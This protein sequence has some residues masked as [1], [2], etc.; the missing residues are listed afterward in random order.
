MSSF[1][2]KVS[3][4]MAIDPQTNQTFVR[5][6]LQSI[7]IDQSVRPNQLVLV[8][9]GPCCNS[10]KTLI[11]RFR[12]EVELRVIHNKTKLG[13]AHCLNIGLDHCEHELV[14]RMDAD[15]VCYR[16]RLERQVRRFVED[17]RLDILSCWAKIIDEHGGTIGLR[18]L[19]VEHSDII[20]RLWRCPLIHPAVMYRKSKIQSIGGYKN[21][22]LRR[23]DYDLWFR[24]AE[25]GMRFGN[26]SE[27]LL[28]YRQVSGHRSKDK[29]R[30]KFQQAAIG[31]RGQFRLEGLTWKI[32]LPLSVIGLSMLPAW[33]Y[34]F[35]R[36]YA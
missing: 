3:V 31:V 9:D 35:V 32:L 14:A 17:T 18:R 5:E 21:E 12:E 7:V 6:A 4:L 29:W 26:L 30:V 2:P 1:E 24:C 15:D 36:K 33:L 20:D 11:G 34:R 10:L 27:I 16:E 19:P 8:V 25:V 28:C 22:L 13:L 23:Q